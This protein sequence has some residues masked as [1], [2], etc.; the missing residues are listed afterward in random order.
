MNLV[1]SAC[2]RVDVYTF[3]VQL[4]DDKIYDDR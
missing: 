1:V 2:S 3:K 4:Q